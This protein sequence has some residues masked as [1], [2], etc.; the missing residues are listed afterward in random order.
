MIFIFFFWR[1]F[2]LGTFHS[3]PAL[4]FLGGKHWGVFVFFKFLFKDYFCMHSGVKLLAGWFGD[5][6]IDTVGP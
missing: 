4:W 5:M 6:Y 3:F 1:L 2:W